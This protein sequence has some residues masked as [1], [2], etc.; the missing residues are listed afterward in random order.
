MSLDEAL[1]RGNVT[2]EVKAEV[3]G[4]AE[5]RVTQ[6]G[7]TPVHAPQ[8][9][10]AESAARLM[11]L[12]SALDIPYQYERSFR[13]APTT[14]LANRFLLTLNRA[15]FGDTA[16][17]QCLDIGRQLDMPISL[18]Q[19]VTPA[20]AEAACVHFGFEGGTESIICKLY[21]ERAVTEDEREKAVARDEPVLL[22]QA[23]KWAPGD[24]MRVVTNYFWYP[25]A[26]LET[27]RDRIREIFASTDDSQAARF[28]EH[29]LDIAASRVDANRLQYLEVLEDENGRRSFD[30]NV[31]EAELQV[32]DL[33]PELNEIRDYFDVKRGSFQAM[34][35]QVR[36]H[37]LGHVAGG[38][39]RNGEEFFNIYHGVT[40]FPRFSAKLG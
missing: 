12:V 16:L 26:P 37:P 27:I 11:Q 13:L 39:H 14:L 1:R 40:S 35:D 9:P 3:A 28:A 17:E 20:F 4:I 34:Y 22:H 18:Q 30:L 10:A 33:Q 5:D 2:H 32:K 7:R 6:R 36:L 29:A 38:V 23:F 25:Q 19:Q 24:D 8:D 21:I 15:D 31:Y